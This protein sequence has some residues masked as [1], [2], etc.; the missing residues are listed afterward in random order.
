[1]HFK[2]PKHFSFQTVFLFTLEDDCKKNWIFCFPSQFWP[3]KIKISQFFSSYLYTKLCDL[4]VLKIRFRPKCLY[5]PLKFVP[6]AVSDENRTMF[7]KV[8]FNPLPFLIHQKE[9]SV[10]IIIGFLH[11]W[12]KRPYML[13][14]VNAASPVECDSPLQI[15]MAV[16]RPFCLN[17]NFLGRVWQPSAE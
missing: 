16:W 14:E 8:N 9:T 5:L 7:F 3:L 13:S 17:S 6:E 1:M 10:Y 4:E 15:E 12:K 11:P 2:A